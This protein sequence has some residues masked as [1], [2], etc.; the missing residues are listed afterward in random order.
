MSQQKKYP[1]L[2]F[3]QL[4]YDSTRWFP[5][6]YR[7]S[8]TAR[9]K[10]GADELNRWRDAV[11]TALINHP[12]FY[13][14][15]DI[16]GR[17]CAAET[18][19]ILRGKY[20][21]FNFREDGK[22]LLM[23]VSMSRI[24]GD[25]KSACVLIE[26]ILRAY[27]GEPLERD[28]YWGY[29]RY[30]EAQKQSQHYTDSR[31]CLVREFADASVP[32]R[33]TMDHKLWTL[34]PPKA[35]VYRDDYTDL[36][37]A[38]LQLAETEYLPMD[39]FFSLCAALA[40]A[41]YCGTDSAA[42]TWAYD[43]RE[44]AEEQRVFGSLHRDIPFVINRKQVTRAELIREARRQIRFGITHSDFPYTLTRPYTERW[45]YAVNVIRVPQIY[46]AISSAPLAVEL[47]PAPEQKI[48]YAMLDIEIVESEGL[49]L[50]YRFSATHYKAESILRFAALVRKYAE[51]LLK[52]E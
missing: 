41:E 46:E 49:M 26:D 39:G 42:L 16:M 23:D 25:G 40:I 4:V 19:D 24:L 28:D 32:V 36:R 10:G 50:N 51:W 35:G 33:P 17:Q 5:S 47:L 14:R 45:N 20:H 15:I 7:F 37:E 8:R 29:I 48:A 34:F 22:D 6:V 9:I 11:Q 27:K 1:L 43:G 30:I 31:E 21:R 3:S 13:S 44:R 38:I 2:P 12:V 18:S 52:D